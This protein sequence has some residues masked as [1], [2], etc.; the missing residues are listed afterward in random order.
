M[1]KISIEL[2]KNIL[3]SMRVRKEDASE[4]IRKLIALELFREKSISMGKAAEIA[5]I[6]LAEFME[7]SAT[8]RIPMHYTMANLQKD[9]ETVRRLGLCLWSQILHL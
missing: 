3:D 2:P 9:R 8:L 5:G 4:A 6:S 7:L 1:V